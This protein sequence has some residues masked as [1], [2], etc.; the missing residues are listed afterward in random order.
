MAGKQ[1]VRKATEKPQVSV[2]EAF[3]QLEQIIADMEAPDVTLESSMQLYRTGVDLLNQCKM[4]LDGIE[5][6]MIILTEE[7]EMPDEKYE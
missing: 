4:K 1:E 3:R 6:E 5:A 7:G 2:E